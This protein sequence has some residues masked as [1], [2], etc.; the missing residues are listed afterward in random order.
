MNTTF[1]SSSL[2]ANGEDEQ[3]KRA[4]PLWLDNMR[5]DLMS[6]VEW[7]NLTTVVYHS[8]Q[9]RLKQNHIQFF[10]DLN[11]VE[12]A[13][14]IDEVERSLAHDS[15]YKG[16][17]G[18]LSRSLD[19]SLSNEVERELLESGSS[20]TNKVN[21]ILER[22]AEG[23]TSLLKRLPSEKSTMRIMLNHEFPGPLRKQA[24]SMFLGHPEARQKY[25]RDV[26]KSRMSTIS[27]RDAD[28]SNKCQIMIDSKFPELDNHRIS[29]LISLMKTTL[30]YY[31]VLS[32]RDL[33]EVN[34]YLCL[35]LAHVFCAVNT[36]ASTANEA[37][38]ALME[39]PRPK[40]MSS[41]TEFLAET[42][43]RVDRELFEHIAQVNATASTGVS[44]GVTTETYIANLMEPHIMRCFVGTVSMPVCCYIWDQ[45]LMLGS[46]DKMIP[47]FAITIMLLLRDQL[48]A[49]PS[50]Q[51]LE[52]TI[53]AH[54]S[55][56]TERKIQA[57]AETTFMN[58]L[59]TK[60]G[61]KRDFAGDLY[62]AVDYE[63]NEFTQNVPGLDQSMDWESFAITSP[64]RRGRNTGIGS[65]SN[66]QT[67]DT[68]RLQQQF[69]QAGQIK[70]NYASKTYKP[71]DVL[72]TKKRFDDHVNQRAAKR[73]EKERK[74]LE[75]R[76]RLAVEEA[77]EE[78]AIA[79]EEREAELHSTNIAKKKELLA[80]REAF[81]ARRRQHEHEL[82]QREAMAMKAAHDDRQ[83]LA[84][85][86]KRRLEIQSEY[87][88]K[89]YKQEV[90]RR[91]R[92][93]NDRL[94]RRGDIDED[95]GKPYLGAD[96]A[97]IMKLRLKRSDGTEHKCEIRA[98][99]DGDS[100][101]D[102]RVRVEYVLKKEG[103]SLDRANKVIKALLTF[104]KKKTQYKGDWS[105]Q[106]S[107][108]SSRI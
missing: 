47:N 76:R 10:S 19:E 18:V 41:I 13:L 64:K 12:K 72:T 102:A 35:P 45:G 108:R 28:I 57:L 15:V 81:E 24:W 87:D 83:R 37:Y 69:M 74:K 11:D 67:Q 104:S 5:S 14:F 61:I 44:S 105:P 27:D 1:T 68:I 58:N 6:T 56:I 84:D 100:Q 75:K 39:L 31:E 98:L 90:D 7:Q 8:V 34:Y 25:E 29:T 53:A 80:R 107:S 94:R 71:D 70:N 3:A 66:R 16:F 17:Q 93:E 49:S 38:L 82:K 106:K 97:P 48:L 99:V 21:M 78:L 73:E 42:L 50:T 40:F 52:R 51:Q 9:D 91:D 43:E 32:Q 54:S 59:R 103:I 30:S 2:K 22:A 65:S 46:F 89:V 85:A 4:L 79:E 96:D 63:R 55:T 23:A 77:E 60:L 36:E 33:E 92:K 95:D 88:E 86:E 101:D 26:I 62:E 20:R